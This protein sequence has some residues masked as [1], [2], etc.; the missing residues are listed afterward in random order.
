MLISLFYLASMMISQAKTKPTGAHGIFHE[1]AIQA[2]T[3]KGIGKNFGNKRNDYL[4]VPYYV[5]GRVVEGIF[6][7]LNNL[8]ERFNRSYWFYLL[9][10]T[11]RY[12]SIGYYMI[13]FGLMT[14]PLLCKALNIYLKMRVDDFGNGESGS[15][16]AA[17]PFNFFCHIMGFGI[18][19]LPF[20]LQKFSWIYQSYSLEFRDAIFYSLIVSSSIIIFNPLVKLNKNSIEQ[21]K[22]RQCV[23]LINLALI[24]SCLSLLNI[25]LA[26]FLSILMV[27]IVYICVTISNNSLRKLLSPLVILIHPLSINYL[28]LFGLSLWFGSES[29]FTV[30]LKRSYHNYKLTLLNHLEDWYI[31][32]NWTFFFGSAFL[33][34]VWL[35]I[36]S[37]L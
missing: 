37:I 14:L 17:L 19:Y 7:S 36:W 18:A 8:L 16:W 26:L 4:S 3:L 30:H 33:F 27:P 1:Y 25:S 5:V 10:S 9:P 22:A 32:G 34:P 6:R 20:M 31:H 21:V 24:L 2:I 15:L 12:I 28:C 23:T 35:Q 13:P 29:D 11:R